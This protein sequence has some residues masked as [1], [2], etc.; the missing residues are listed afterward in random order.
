MEDETYHVYTRMED[1]TEADDRHLAGARKEIRNDL[2]VIIPENPFPEI[3][4]DA[5]PP[6]KFSWVIPKKIAAMAFPRHVENLKFLV[7]QGI[8]HLVTLTAGKKPPVDDMPCLKWTEIPVEEFEVPTIEQIEKFIDICKKADKNNEEVT[9]KMSTVSKRPNVK[10]AKLIY[11]YAEEVEE[12][13]ELEKARAMKDEDFKTKTPDEEYESYPP[14]NFSWF[15]PKK[16]AA[17]GYP[18][19]V[20]NLNY[21]A[22]QGIN[23]LITLSPEKIPP[24]LEC[25]KKM[26]WTE[27]AIKEFGAPTLKQI[28]KFIEICERAEI[29][30][31]TV[32]V[33]CRQGRG[34]TGTMLACYLV[35]FRDMAPERA[36]LTVRVQRPGSCETYE[37]EKMVCHYHDCVRGTITKPDYRM[38]DDKLYFDFSMKYM[39]SDEEKKKETTEDEEKVVILEE[40]EVVEKKERKK[41]KAMVINH[42]IYF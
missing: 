42:K 9:R 11:K 33:H 13:K 27:I 38:V 26:K 25:K 14:Y 41:S 40:G 31:E 36:V 21:L 10:L 7:N 28:I 2:T 4:V 15:V 39:F 16:I 5:Y 1:I 34:R 37:Q 17:M 3:E 24:I 8:T 35:Y 19:T 18:Q 20:A 22:D 30:G 23:H 6:L 12:R 32:G 29:R